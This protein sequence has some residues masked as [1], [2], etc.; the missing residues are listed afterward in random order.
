VAMGGIQYLGIHS[1]VLLSTYTL[2]A[3]KINLLIL[4]PLIA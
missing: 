2:T 1:G 3:D 4:G